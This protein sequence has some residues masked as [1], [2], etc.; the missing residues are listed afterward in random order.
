MAQASAVEATFK[1]L[2]GETEISDPVGPSPGKYPA[3]DIASLV[4][5]VKTMHGL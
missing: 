1:V 4:G 2:L 5:Q 3:P